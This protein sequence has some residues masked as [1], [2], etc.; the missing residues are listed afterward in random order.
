MLPWLKAPQKQVNIAPTC[1]YDFKEERE[2]GLSELVSEHR[3]VALVCDSKHGRTILPLSRAQLLKTTASPE[4]DFGTF[5][6]L[7]LRE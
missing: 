2:G 7:R 6:P 1:L 4:P 5:G 3:C